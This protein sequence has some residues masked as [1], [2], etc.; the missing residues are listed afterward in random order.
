MNKNNF[1][2]IILRILTILHRTINEKELTKE[3]I[4]EEEKNNQ[5]V[6]NIMLSDKYKTIFKSIISYFGKHLN[7]KL[8]SYCY[9]LDNCKQYCIDKNFTG[10]DTNKYESAL[11]TSYKGICSV[12]NFYEFALSISPETFFKTNEFSLS[13][14]YLRNFFINLTSRILDQPYFGYI[15]QML[16]H[17]HTNGYELIELVDSA[18]NFVLTCK[19]GSDKDLFIEFIVNTKEIFIH[20]LINIYSYGTNVINKKIEIENNDHLQLMKKKYEEYKELVYE[21]KEKR[22]TFEN[23]NVKNL[24]NLDNYDNDLICIICYKEIADHRLKPCMHRGCKECLLTYMADNV[25]CFMCRQP[26]ESIQMIP[27][28]EIEKEKLKNKNNK[29]E[30]N[31]KGEQNKNED[32]KE[33]GV[34]K[35]ISNKKD[36][37]PNNRPLLDDELDESFDDSF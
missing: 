35:N 14:I 20:T 4:I 1:E 37:I 26:I 33:E 2:R 34:K 13:L 10:K 24:Q 19:S 23:E 28:E 15:E 3:E 30:E 16:N 7:T 22:S 6:K 21:L 12:I 31:K 5:N 11:K 8:T 17:I 25:K 36:Y 18:V 32:I 29:N 27:K 9:D